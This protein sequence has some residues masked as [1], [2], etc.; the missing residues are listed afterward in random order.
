LGLVR[1][2]FLGGLPGKRF[3][4]RKRRLSMENAE[5]PNAV[6]SLPPGNP[7][8]DLRR[9][10]IHILSEE[11]NSNTKLVYAFR[12]R[13]SFAAWIGPFIVLGSFIV[14]T[15]KALPLQVTNWWG[16]GIALFFIVFCY[17]AL[18]PYIGAGIERQVWE[19]CDRLRA[20]I[21][22]LYN[23][24][25]YRPDLRDYEDRIRQ[26]VTKGYYAAVVPI[27]VCAVAV[28]AIAIFLGGQVPPAGQVQGAGTSQQ[29]E[30]AAEPKGD[31]ASPGTPADGARTAAAESRPKTE[32]FIMSHGKKTPGRP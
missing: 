29:I 21:V 8:A 10:L 20:M 30:P 14:A 9:E 19:Q 1:R 24:P 17:L 32:P 25:N 22:H 3:H 2:P 6:E 4:S 31:L 18:M 13:V 15:G 12:N 28:S 23:N 7:N 16:V 26:S 11:I 27:M 5:R